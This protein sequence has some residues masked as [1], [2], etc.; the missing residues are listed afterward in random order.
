MKNKY[1]FY[2]LSWTWGLPMTLTG[3]IV[4]LVLMMFGYKPKKY[5]YCYYFEIGKY[6]GGIELG[7]FFLTEKNAPEYIKIHEL[8]HSINNTWFG[9][10]MP[11]LV[12]I[13]SMIR[14]HYRHMREK[15]GKPCKTD[16]YDIWFERIANECGEK[17]INN[18]SK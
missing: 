14:Y 6:W 4:A 9:P 8:G 18:T 3:A 1:L 5:G 11:I 7:M 10:F 17:F 2:I 15:I 13:P 16:Y 12:S